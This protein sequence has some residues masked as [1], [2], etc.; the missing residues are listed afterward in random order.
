V[1]FH[2]PT[3][4]VTGGF[5]GLG[6]GVITSDDR[7]ASIT[8][9]PSSGVEGGQTVT[10]AGSDLSPG[11]A[12]GWCQGVALPDGVTVNADEWCGLG[13][14]GTGT[15]APDGTFGGPLR[16]HR[17]LYIP[18]LAAWVDCTDADAQC[19][20]GAADIANIPGTGTEVGVTFG[21][22]PPPPA[23]R[24]TVSLSPSTGVLPDEVIAVT[25]S[26]F[27]AGA[28]VDLFQCFPGAVPTHP[29]A[30]GLLHTSIVA[31]GDGVFTTTLS[32][33]SSLANAAAIVGQGGTTY[34][35]LAMPT[36]P[37]LVVAVEAVDFAGTAAAAPVMMMSP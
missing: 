16:L 11:A 26:G 25:G 20:V 13:V 5:L 37:C 30:C 22:P 10:V 19:T 17:F 32:I 2:H 36:G 27:R 6:F 7:P 4:A 33:R 23:T 9:T 1:S 3:N 24:G 15:V 12:A 28:Q 31:D 18:A 14:N 35:C 34:D 21:A 29:E 8:V